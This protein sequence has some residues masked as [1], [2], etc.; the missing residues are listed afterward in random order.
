MIRYCRVQIPT[1]AFMWDLHEILMVVFLAIFVVPVVLFLWVRF[2]VS[3]YFSA[4]KWKEDQDEQEKAT[5]QRK[6]NGRKR[7]EWV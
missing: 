1:W 3:G 5:S 6:T 2:L 7:D 4:I